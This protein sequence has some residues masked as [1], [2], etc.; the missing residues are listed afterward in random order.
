MF[1]GTY[2]ILLFGSERGFS[3]LIYAVFDVPKMVS[4]IFQNSLTVILKTIDFSLVLLA[5]YFYSGLSALY[6]QGFPTSKL[7]QKRKNYTKKRKM[8]ILYVS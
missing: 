6:F 1:G 7:I 4:R 2:I 8:S 5:I 3:S